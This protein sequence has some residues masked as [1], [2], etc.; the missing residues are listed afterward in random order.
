MA[1]SAASTESP[2]RCLS[3]GIRWP[4]ASDAAR[5]VFSTASPQGSTIFSLATKNLS[6]HSIQ[7][8]EEI[9]MDQ[10]IKPA[11]PLETK[12]PSTFW[13]SGCLWGLVTRSCLLGYWPRR[14]ARAVHLL[15]SRQKRNLAVR[16]LRRTQ[17]AGVGCRG[18]EFRFPQNTW[19]KGCNEYML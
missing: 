14:T 17:P 7:A 19:S 3:P 13:K 16:L 8:M 12:D 5:S 10:Q 2:V 1:S 15:S 6:S 18:D 9:A 11:F 4:R